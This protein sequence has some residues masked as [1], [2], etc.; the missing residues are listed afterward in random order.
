MDF[1]YREFFIQAGFF[2]TFLSFSI[3]PAL[4]AENTAVLASSPPSGMKTPIKTSPSSAIASPDKPSSLCK[5]EV[6]SYEITPP[7]NFASTSPVSCERIS[8]KGR[9]ASPAPVVASAIPIAA[10]NFLCL[11]TAS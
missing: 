2:R 6:F 10:T 7:E 11:L 5:R 1:R 8:R 9:Y 4:F 3:H